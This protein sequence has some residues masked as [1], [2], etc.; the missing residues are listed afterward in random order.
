MGFDDRIED[1]ASLFSLVKHV[2]A[3]RQADPHV[4]VAGLFAVD[5]FEIGQRLVVI[6]RVEQA[7]HQSPARAG[8]RRV[9]LD[10]PAKILGALVGGL[11]AMIGYPAQ[12]HCPQVVGIDFQPV[13]EAVDRVEDAVDGD[14]PLGDGLPDQPGPFEAMLGLAVEKLLVLAQVAAGGVQ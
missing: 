13:V 10:D 9:A 6:G 14:V 11:A 3:A 2:L 8:S 7:E 12:L 5:L 4:R 1:R